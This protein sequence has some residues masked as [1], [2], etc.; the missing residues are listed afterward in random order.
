M[1]KSTSAAPMQNW[2]IMKR[3]DANSKR[4]QVPLSPVL[5]QPGQLQVKGART[6]KTTDQQ[7]NGART[8]NEQLIH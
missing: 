7:T 2:T 3:G 5:P 4:I 1:V 8:A 6:R